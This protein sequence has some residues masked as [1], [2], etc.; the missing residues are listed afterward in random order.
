MPRSTRA[1]L[2]VSIAAA[3]GAAAAAPSAHAAV[4]LDPL[5]KD[6]AQYQVYAGDRLLGTEVF[7]LQPK[8]D[9]VLV[10][11]NVNEM[12]PTPQGD[13]QLQKKVGMSVKAL[14]FDLLNYTSETHF[15]GRFLRRGIELADTT[16]TSYHEDSVRGYGDTMARP[17]GRVYVID[18]QAFVLFDVLLRS[19][20]GKMIGERTIPVIVLT[21]PRD[22]V[23]DV[24]M[25]PGVTD[26][27]TW[28]GRKVT[29]RRVTLS[30]GSS[31]FTA[32]VAKAGHMLRLEQAAT[33][34]R[35]ERDIRP[36]SEAEAAGSK[37]S[38]GLTPRPWKPHRR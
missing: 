27:I 9:S 26:T 33:G 37:S 35:V 8:G 31:E 19:L 25:R 16:F 14:D 15:G 30:D 20:H 28:S 17:P 21:E 12:I 18:S 2:V 23:L 38:G 6:V 1:R 34:L 3:L 4:R 11:S 36:P 22:T 32:W 13:V 7:S 29:A 24:L 5:I 10:V